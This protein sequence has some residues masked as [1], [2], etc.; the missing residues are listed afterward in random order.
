[1]N[2]DLETTEM[3]LRPEKQTRLR[4]EHAG[5][6]LVDTHD[7]TSITRIPRGRLVVG[8]NAPDHQGNP[9]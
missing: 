6:L 4:L 7:E 5:H 3:S 2:C 9:H 8:W 1:M